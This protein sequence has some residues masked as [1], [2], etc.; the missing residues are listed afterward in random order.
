MS[1]EQAY[2]LAAMRVLW[3]SAALDQAGAIPVWE[4][5]A[6]FWLDVIEGRR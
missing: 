5:E 6:A 1:L 2:F 4:A 3:L